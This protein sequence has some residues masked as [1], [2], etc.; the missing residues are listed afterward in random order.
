MSKN[1]QPKKEPKKETTPKQEKEVVE[2]EASKLAKKIIDLEQQIKAKDQ[3][4]S[5]QQAKTNEA[6][7]KLLA[8]EQSFK[9]LV[10][11]AETK[12]NSLIKAKIEENDVKFKANLA[13]AK[14]YAIK[15]QALDLID[16]IAE[17]ENACNY[18][19]TDPKLVN[20][21]K[22]FKMLLTKFHNILSRW[23]ITPIK[24]EI[25]KEFDPA[26]MECFETVADQSKQNNTI[27]EVLQIGYKLY[28]HIL[29]PALVKVIKNN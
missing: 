11:Q 9:D 26:T 29:K 16:V 5:S 20:Y 22:G 28:D 25:G 7:N 15:D 10:S 12:A 27:V 8:L 2:S 19:L 1:K 17:F 6:N 4:I 21:Q 14:K 23:H 24:P 13:E 3:E 18:P